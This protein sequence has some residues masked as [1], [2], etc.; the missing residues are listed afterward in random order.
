MWSAQN[1]MEDHDPVFSKF[2]QAGLIKAFFSPEVIADQ[3]DVGL[4][5][6][7]DGLD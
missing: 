6:L 7:G 4:G 3:R 5:G 2:F 1:A